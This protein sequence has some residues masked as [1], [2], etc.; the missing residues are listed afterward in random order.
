M[1]KL[2]QGLVKTARGL[3]MGLLRQALFRSGFLVW[4]TQHPRRDVVL[5]FHA[6][7]KQS[8]EEFHDLLQWL[9]KHFEIVPLEAIVNR[10]ERNAGE[11]S[12]V[13]ALTFDDGLRNHRTVVYPILVDL[14]L[15]ATF[16]ICPGLIERSITT[17][18]WEFWCRIPWLP[19]SS[20]RELLARADAKD[21]VDESAILEW[22]KT[23]PLKQRKQVEDHIRLR[24][25]AF[26]FSAAERELYRL[27]S[28]NE[29]SEIDPGLIN[30]GSH[31]MTH[32]DLPPLSPEELVD[33][34]EG[35]RAVLEQRLGRPVRDFC[36][37]DGKHDDRVA[38]AVANVYRSA[39]T[40][41]C[42]GVVSEDSRHALKRI[43]ASVDLQWVSWLLAT[44]TGPSH[45]C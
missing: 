44:H 9:S 27:M 3:T 30:V 16:Y 21:P 15:P 1:E 22:M 35:S 7:P 24:T 43:G 25:P 12:T 37:P 32:C 20:R 40:T 34:L 29:L 8:A 23:I 38:R 18:T 36:Y 33:E 28:W 6:I 10:V 2:H 45:R 19:E 41:V 11:K 13:L 17:W 31:T 39:V 26:D 5:M 14:R 42:G 4:M